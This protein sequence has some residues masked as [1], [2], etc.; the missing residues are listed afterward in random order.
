MYSPELVKV[1][2]KVHVVTIFKVPQVCRTRRLPEMFRSGLYVHFWCQAFHFAS[3][4]VY[5][6]MYSTMIFVSYF[7]NQRI[8]VEN[9][10]LNKLNDTLN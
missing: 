4:K 5:V 1:H 8:Y 2:L 3:I 9:G 10:T 7:T 6:C